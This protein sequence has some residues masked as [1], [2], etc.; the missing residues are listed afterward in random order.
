MLKKTYL[1][2]IVLGKE[3]KFSPTGGE[4]H[5]V[6]REGFRLVRIRERLER[7]YPPSRPGGR[8][9]PKGRIK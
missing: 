7:K 2:G 4:G 8:T 1:F 3:I 5:G 9:P 6:A